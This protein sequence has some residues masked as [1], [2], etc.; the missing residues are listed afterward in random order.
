MHYFGNTRAHTHARINIQTCGY[1]TSSSSSK[2]LSCCHRANENFFI[3]LM[4]KPDEESS[5]P[6]IDSV[7]LK[8]QKLLPQMREDE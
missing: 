2:Y 5:M 1:A 7:L 4:G 3:L 6:H 8:F